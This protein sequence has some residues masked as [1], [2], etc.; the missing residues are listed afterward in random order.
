[1]HQ[2]EDNLL[3]LSLNE[4]SD[5]SLCLLDITPPWYQY[6]NNNNIYFRSIMV[7]DLQKEF[8]F[9]CIQERIYN[10]IIIILY[11]YT[12]TIETSLYLLEQKNLQ[13]LYKYI[14]L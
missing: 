11:K 1:M 7:H 6:Y 5:L 3:L 9:I 2:K 8:S 14:V 4:L 13:S 12:L 10:S